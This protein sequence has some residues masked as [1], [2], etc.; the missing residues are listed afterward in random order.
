M[1]IKID[2]S[3]KIIDEAV[4]KHMNCYLRGKQEHKHQYRND[5]FG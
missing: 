2:Q 3:E 1:D 4:E 5:G